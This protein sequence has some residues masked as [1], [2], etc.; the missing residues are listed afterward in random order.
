MS[1]NPYRVGER[2]CLGCFG[3]RQISGGLSNPI[4][5]LTRVVPELIPAQE[6]SRIVDIVGELGLGHLAQGSAQ[7]LQDCGVAVLQELRS[8]GLCQ[9]AAA[10]D[11]PGLKRCCRP[12]G[13][14]SLCW[15]AAD[16][17][18]PRP[19]KHLGI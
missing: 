19:E 6:G 9:L 18:Q 12:S 11:V 15:A 17:Q 2:T 1:W 13:Q 16:A 7:R 3:A 8:T 10:A 5:L 14:F 4:A